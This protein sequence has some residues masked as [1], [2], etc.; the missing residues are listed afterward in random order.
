MNTN[1]LRIDYLDDL[2]ICDRLIK[3]YENSNDKSPGSTG[4]GVVPEIKNSTDLEL[5]ND[6][7]THEYL[8]QLQKV[9]DNYIKEFPFC[10]CY[11]PWGVSENIRIQHYAPPEQAF[12]TWHTER[13]TNLP[14]NASRH[15]VFM[16]YLN[17]VND[18]GETEWYHQDIK[19]SPKKGLTAIWPADWTYTHRGLVSKTEHKY[20]VT[21]WFSYLN[22]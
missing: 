4:L 5:G 12:K 7:L 16:T 13:C 10:N 1:F 18:G 8:K 20:I 2:S 14:L 17:D 11:A 6:S 15:L 22:S 21:G 3:F 19:I 9:V